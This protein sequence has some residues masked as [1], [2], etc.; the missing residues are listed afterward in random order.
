[1][2]RIKCTHVFNNKMAVI[3]SSVFQ[4]QPNVPINVVS[5][6]VKSKTGGLLSVFTTEF[7]HFVLRYSRYSCYKIL[8]NFVN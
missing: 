1:M 4:L 8:C 2:L 6:N 5:Y 7:S 3:L